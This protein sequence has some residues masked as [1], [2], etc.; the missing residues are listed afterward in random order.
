MVGVSRVRE[1]SFAVMV[2]LD[3]GSEPG[4]GRSVGR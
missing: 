4:V 1:R 3:R 2:L